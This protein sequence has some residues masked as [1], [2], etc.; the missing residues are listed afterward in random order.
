MSL[1][2]LPAWTQP[3]LYRQKKFD[4]LTVAEIESLKSRIRQFRHEKP[5]VSVVIPVWNEQDNIFRTL[6]SLSSSIT[7]HKV[8]I[9]VINNNSTDK[10]QQVLDELGVINYLQPKQGTPFA[11]QMGLDKARGKYFLCADADTLYPPQW[12]NLMVA[13][14]ASNTGVTGVYGRYS[15]IPPEGSNRFGLW[16]YELFTAI[17]IRVRQR[18]REY[19]NVY[20]FNMGLVTQI[21]KEVGGFEVRGDRK[22]AGV[23]GSDYNNEAED[24]RMALNLSA[25]G[26]LSLVTNAKARVFSSSRRLMDDGSIWQ[27][28]VNRAKRQLR[29]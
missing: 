21:G 11:R 1:F 5:D 6:S 16:F 15:F 20:G 9:V 27:A 28:F 13:P 18:K 22:Y 29:I 8:E 12:I 3:H 4:D 14:M 10:T 23:V 17:I 7:D 2:D 25:R 19:M 26:K 24:G